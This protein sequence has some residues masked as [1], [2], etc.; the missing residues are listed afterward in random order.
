MIYNFWLLSRQIILNFPWL[1]GCFLKKK[2]EKRKKLLAVDWMKL[3]FNTISLPCQTSCCCYGFIYGRQQGFGL[4]ISGVHLD[5][6]FGRLW[7]TDSRWWLPKLM[8]GAGGCLTWRKPQGV[9]ELI[10]YQT[11]W[12][13]SVNFY[14]ICGD[15]MAKSIIDNE[16][17]NVSKAHQKYP[18]KDFGK[19]C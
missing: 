9:G 1:K 11:A 10:Q 5:L 12:E 19:L 6:A 2:K 4:V 16:S 14:S 18:S 3:V 8:E 13:G 15:I 7:S 17:I